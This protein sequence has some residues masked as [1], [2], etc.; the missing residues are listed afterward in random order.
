MNIK[1]Y[2]TFLDIIMPVIERKFENQKE[3]LS[4][5]KGCSLCCKTVDMPFSELE[6]E[7]L[8]TGFYSLDSETQKIVLNNIEK[9]AET[10]DKAACPFLIDNECSVYK[11]RG[12][13][14]RTF[15]LLLISDEQEYTIPFCVHKGLSYS[16]VFDEN[17]QKLSPEK[18]KQM[19]YNNDPMFYTLSRK[20]MFEL[21][22]AKDLDL[23]SGESKPLK[24]WL[25]MFREGLLAAD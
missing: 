23:K 10:S 25:K 1:N 6:F 9:I 24:E 5:E 11:Y 2:E 14:C 20:R 8:K 7:Y 18:V 15:G 22:I 19:G 4:C 3:Y 12:L 13:I 17:T 21:Q 16:K